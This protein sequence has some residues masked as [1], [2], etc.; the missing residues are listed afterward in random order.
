[1]N[2]KPYRP[3]VGVALFNRDGL[4][5]AGHRFA[6]SGPETIPAGFEWQMPQGGIDEGEDVVEAARRELWEET[7][8][9]SVSLLAATEA[10]WSYD[11]PPY[12]GP[13]T[14]KL[15]PFRGQRQLWVA[16]RLEGGLDEINVDV[17]ECLE[18]PEFDAWGFFPLRSLPKLVVDFRRPVY[19][20]VAEAFAPFAVPV[21]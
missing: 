12:A 7:G 8:V 10:W 19:D 13:L 3:N 6:S 15:A 21:S 9:K 14:H 20:K 2:D 5:F 17:P 1:M 11:F 4:V 18:D 16:F